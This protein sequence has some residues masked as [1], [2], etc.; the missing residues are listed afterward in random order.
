VSRLIKEKGQDVVIEAIN[1]IKKQFPNIILLIVGDGRDRKYLED[2][3]KEKELQKTV[4]FL[5]KVDRNEC[6]KL[7]QFTDLFVLTSRR[8]YKESFGLVYLEANACK[9]V[10]LA[11]NTGG[12]SEAVENGVSGILVN[13]CDVDEIANTIVSLL[14]NEHKRREMEEKAYNRVRNNFSNIDMAKK[15]ICLI[16]SV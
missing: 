3:V 10:V 6:C 13:P 11:G 7:Y 9:K 2:L 16:E 5:G 8:G 4:I 14:I 15:I 12:V 1:K